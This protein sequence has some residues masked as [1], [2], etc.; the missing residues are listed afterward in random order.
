MA[1]EDPPARTKGEEAFEGQYEIGKYFY[2][3]P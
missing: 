2:G 3:A 1:A